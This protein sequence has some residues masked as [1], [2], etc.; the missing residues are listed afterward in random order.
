MS[1]LD[2]VCGAS[3]A[4]WCPESTGAPR[5]SVHQ[6]RQIVERVAVQFREIVAARTTA[7]ASGT[8]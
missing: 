6:D 2:N 5:T 1:A 8:R 7:S 4:M 3:S